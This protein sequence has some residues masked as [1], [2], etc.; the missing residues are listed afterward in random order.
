VNITDDGKALGL[1]RHF[2]SR[3]QYGAEIANLVRMASINKPNSK[4]AIA[5]SAVQG[6]RNLS[7]QDANDQARHIVK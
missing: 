1:C 7:G 3:H 4:V 2:G 6:P 5:I